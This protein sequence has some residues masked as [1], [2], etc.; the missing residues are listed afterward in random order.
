ML[1]PSLLTAPGHGERIPGT[2]LRLDP[3][4]DAEFVDLPVAGRARRIVGVAR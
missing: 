1:A 3:L 2:G 4:E